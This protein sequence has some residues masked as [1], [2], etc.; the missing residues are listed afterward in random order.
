MAIQ[1]NENIKI[2]APNP[3]DKR[4]LSNRVSGG[5]QLP[6]SSHTEV[7]N[8]IILSERYIGLT[9]NVLGEEHWF[10]DSVT[11][12][13]LI[14]K[15]YD[16]VI[17]N[18]EFVTGA[19]NIGL[20]SGYTGIQ[21]L[22]ITNIATTG[23]TGFYNSLYNY[24][25]RGI[26]GKIH[27]S[28]PTD[29]IY[30]RGYVKST[31]PVKSW[32]WNEYLG[33][34]NLLG[35]ILID[36]NIENQIGTYQPGVTYYT[37]VG[38]SLP[39]TATTWNTGTAYNNTSNVVISS[40][41]G[42][43]TTGNT[44]TIGGPIYSSKTDRVLGLRTIKTKTPD[45]IKVNYD[46]AFVY[47]SGATILATGKNVGT[48]IGIYTGNTGSALKFKT[49]TGSGATQITS[50]G[51]NIIIYSSGGTGGTGTVF[52]SDILVSIEA[53]K[54]FGKYV[55][56]DIIPASG[57]T[58]NDVIKMA[59]AEALAPTL[60]LVV[61]SSA[62]NFGLSAKTITVG[63]S[64]T[65]NTG[66]AH[67][68]T[69]IL[70]GKRGGSWSTLSTSTG[71]TSYFQSFNDSGNRFNT[72]AIDY[73]YTV[74][75]SAGGSGQ[76]TITVTPEAYAAP[77]F[78]P[79]Y[80]GTIASYETQ[81]Q[82]ES[83]NVNT[84]IA[85]NIV[86]NRIYVKL[87][88]YRIQRSVDGGAYSTIATVSSIGALS[89]AISS[90]LDSA[91]AGGAT[92]I[93]YRIQVDDEYQNNNNSSVYTIAFRFASYYGYSTNTVLT[94]GQIVGLGN[95]ALLSSR[96]RTM[97]LTAPAPQYTYVSYPASF[98]DLTNAIMD[99]AAPVLGAFTKLTAV[100]VTNG[101]GQAVSNN[102]YKSNALGAFTNNVVAFS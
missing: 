25:F 32:I 60:S 1:Y 71:A 43:L 96:V 74:V 13:N 48:G 33:G 19:T 8:T 4:Y 93:A 94:S 30:K 3:L 82:R 51:D 6:Y 57:K 53:G 55:N 44:Q 49:L 68:V 29:G 102:V 73:R 47:V 40:V 14:E 98:G 36:G 90:Y 23:Y 34:S 88:T 54:T 45:T 87:A 99:G 39:Y 17:P 5:S 91:A 42:S 52:T 101:H 18:T 7:Y 70:E 50:S 22:P 79:T 69:A 61:D 37:G 26:D 64:Y 9:V 86:S 21:S 10:R 20:F 46:E 81:T 80:T 28:K 77:S 56:G 15:K 16:S 2:A 95:Q 24:Y 84:T 75:D 59:L 100:T 11:D 89:T 27:V 66:G 31:Y 83:G 85:G 58:A 38:S 65:I 41:V 67:A 62:L 92:T 97:T 76:T 35:W 78:S 12:G 72:T 63:F